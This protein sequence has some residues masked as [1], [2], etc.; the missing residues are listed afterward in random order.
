MSLMFKVVVACVVATLVWVFALTRHPR[1]AAQVVAV[2][3]VEPR[4]I[5][6]AADRCDVRGCGARAYARALFEPVSDEQKTSAVD[7]CGHHYRTAPM[8]LHE[9]AYHVIDETD[10]VS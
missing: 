1:V 4:G 5:L 7:L 2:T 8:S 3:T 6:T 10:L 9:L